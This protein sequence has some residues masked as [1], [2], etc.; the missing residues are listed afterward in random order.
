VRR[1]FL[2]GLL[3]E[4]SLPSFKELG[5]IYLELIPSAVKRELELLF[6]LAGLTELNMDSL[7]GSQSK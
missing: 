2:A 4:L 5:L 6:A 7:R 3:S 1:V